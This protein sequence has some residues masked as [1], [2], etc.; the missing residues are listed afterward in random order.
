MTGAVQMKKTFNLF[1]HKSELGAYQVFNSDMSEYL[2]GSVC[3]GSQDVEM[4]IP[5]VNINNLLIDKL[6]TDVQKERAESQSRVNLLLDR[7]SKLKAITHD[8]EVSV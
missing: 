4:E 8:V 7:I 5:E 2:N 1:L 6:E 3:L